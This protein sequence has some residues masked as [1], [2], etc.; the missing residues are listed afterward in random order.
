MRLSLGVLFSLLVA[1][2]DARVYSENDREV[3]APRPLGV[4]VPVCPESV[5]P[6]GARG[7]WTEVTV[8]PDGSV[9]SVESTEAV[10]SNGKSEPRYTDAVRRSGCDEKVIA[11]VKQMKF[12]PAERDGQ[13]VAYRMRMGIAFTIGS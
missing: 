11:A 7:V 5:R 2:G 4:I 1:C 6:S 9:A 13:P 8:R 10:A 12:K 3:V